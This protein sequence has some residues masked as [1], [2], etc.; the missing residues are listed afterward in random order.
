MLHRDFGMRSAVL[1]A[2]CLL[3]A[4]AATRA[5]ETATESAPCGRPV[6]IVSAAV[7]GKSVEETARLVEREA[8]AGADLIVLPE[9]WPGANRQYTLQDP[10]IAAMAEVAR[11]HRTYIVSPIYRRDGTAVYNSSVLIDRQGKIAGV[12]DKVYPVMHEPNGKGGEFAGVKGR[13]GSDAPVFQTDFGRV[14]MA[15]CFDGQFPE[16]WQRLEDHGAQIVLFSSMYSAGRSL[17]AYATLH[18]Y[19]VVSCCNSGE[20]QAYDMTGDRLLMEHNKV[21]RIVLDMDRCMVHLNDANNHVGRNN[22]RIAKLL[23]ENPGVVV[24]KYMHPEDWEVLK[25]VRPGVDVPAL[26]EKYGIRDLRT[27]LRGQR[28]EADRIRGG[29]FK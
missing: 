9:V 6:R 11:R 7:Y 23:A 27:Y 17:G 15:I 1:A 25:A 18:H 16:V 24:N 3:G 28:Q 14:G 13:S 20:C 26:M 2:G 22:G 8:A 5:A 10:P 4:L 29:S 21:S 19:Y 12:Y